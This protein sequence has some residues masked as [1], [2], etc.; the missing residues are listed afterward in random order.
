MASHSHGCLGLSWPLITNPPNLGVA[1][2][3][4]S[5]YG[6]V[7][8]RVDMFWQLGGVEWNGIHP[9]KLTVRP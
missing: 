1:S 2:H 7:S 8:A 6:V 4:R 5:Q 9:L 3:L